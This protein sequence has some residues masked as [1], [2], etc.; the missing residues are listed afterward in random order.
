MK[1]KTVKEK[2]FNTITTIFCVVTVLLCVGLILGKIILN[3]YTVVGDSMSPSYIDG[4]IVCTEKYTAEKKLQID[5]VIVLKSTISN[6]HLIK[7]VAGLPGDRLQVLD[8]RLFRN[9]TLVMDG[10][11]RMNT[12]GILEEMVCVPEGH[13]F[14]LGDNRNYSQDSREIGMIPLENVF[15][16][17]TGKI[18]SKRAAEARGH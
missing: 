4:E 17:V 7:R 5:D 2:R 8:G 6:K 14:V 18:I 10:F 11:P 3:P 13:V 15:A 12:G 1:G 9:G 16:I